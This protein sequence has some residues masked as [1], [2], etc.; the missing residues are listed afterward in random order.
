MR[1]KIDELWPQTRIT[2]AFHNSK[3]KGHIQCKDALP[4]ERLLCYR[5][6]LFPGLELHVKYDW[7]VMDPNT[8][9]NR[10]LIQHF[11][12]LPLV[13][14]KLLDVYRRCT[15]QTTALLSEMSIFCV[16]AGCE[17]WMANCA[18]KHESQSLSD[19]PCVCIQ[20]YLD[21]Y[22]KTSDHTWTFSISNDCYI[23]GDIL[24]VV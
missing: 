10:F 7:W 12:V 15:Y 16:S 18:S 22:M 21:T 3:T 1:A 19:K 13:T 17:I 20:L 4:I 5:R 2:M 11:C 23:I 9:W 6:D 8:H 14:R 24:C